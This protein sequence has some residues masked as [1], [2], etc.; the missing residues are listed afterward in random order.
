MTDNKDS[1]ITDIN[2]S[3]SVT[4]EV[5]EEDTGVPPP[6]KR[7]KLVGIFSNRLLSNLSNMDDV[8]SIDDTTCMV[9]SG[10]SVE[11]IKINKTL[12]SLQSAVL[13]AQLF[14]EMKEKE[15]IIVISD[16]TPTAFK[17][18]KDVFYAKEREFTPENV[19][20]VLEA[21]KFYLL[22]E[23]QRQCY[24]FLESMDIK[25]WW[26]VM[27]LDPPLIDPH[28]ESALISKSKPLLENINSVINDNNLSNLSIRWFSRLINNDIFMAPN[29]VKI[30]EICNDYCYSGGKALAEAR[31]IMKSYLFNC[32]RWPLMDREYYFNNISQSELLD[33][34]DHLDIC[35]SFIYDWPKNFAEE[36]R[37]CCRPRT[38]VNYFQLT[39]YDIKNLK[40]G[41]K[42][43]ARDDTGMYRECEIE[44]IEFETIH[45]NAIKEFR[46]K[47]KNKDSYNGLDVKTIA[48]RYIFSIESLH[49]DFHKYDKMYQSNVPFLKIRRGDNV[50]YDMYYEEWNTG[51]VKDIATVARKKTFWR[52]YIIT[53]NA[54]ND[55]DNEIDHFIHCWKY[56]EIKKNDK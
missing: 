34:Q 8:S 39:E 11:E 45:K 18:L 21:S 52:F 24:K 36:S 2:Q 31:L 10:D 55:T 6:A 44:K 15:E 49:F 42:V 37:W 47:G 40:A 7:I 17:F 56:S 46:Y 14:G 20:D 27:L 23:L 3:D 25:Q 51:I 9:G 35:K 54:R 32:I 38:P 50:R 29:E 1:D 5:K 30:W 16:I 4:T 13:K 26:S 41:D 53:P 43:M 19:L 22:E 28:L 48:D 33:Q 12:F